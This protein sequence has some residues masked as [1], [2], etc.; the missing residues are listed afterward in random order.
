MKLKLLFFTLFILSLFSQCKHWS[1]LNKKNTPEYCTEQF[2][3]HINHLEF[4]K[5]KQYGTE[6]TNELLD[7]MKSLVAMIPEQSA[8]QPMKIIITSCV[9]NDE[10]AKCNYTA[11]GKK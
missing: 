1:A 9:I 4:D 6:P 2:L 11:N 7:V 10:Q 8:P 3:Y 5:A